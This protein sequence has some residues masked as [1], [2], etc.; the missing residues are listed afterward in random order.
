MSDLSLAAKCAF[1]SQPEAYPEG[2]VTVAVHETH[3]SYVFLT[4]QHAWK[5]KKPVRETYLDFS[6]LERRRINC[7]R[8]VHLNRRL[9]GSVYLGV[10][11]LTE[12]PSGDLRIG[13]SGRVVEWLVQ[14]RRLPELRMLDRAIANKSVT[15]EDITQVGRRLV[16]FYK[17]TVSAALPPSQY[18]QRI[19]ADVKSSACELRKFGLPRQ[20][21]DSVSERAL[22]CIDENRPL[23]EARA[24]LLLDAHGD[25]RPEHVCLEPEPV[26]I[27]CLEFSDDLRILD[28][29][30]ELSFFSIECDRLGAT[31]VGNQVL[32]V[33]QQ[34]TGDRV[35]RALLD[36]YARQH[37]L[38]RAKIA[39]WHL[40][41]TAR[42]DSTR[43]MKKAVDYLERASLLH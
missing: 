13:G 9:A 36:L 16:R 3:M 20:R 7:E 24:P 33:Y 32:E 40:K 12:E 34:E 30:S 38:T 17:T 1:L 23:V 2:T 31:W 5:L 14:M 27:D 19:Q 11:P 25:L 18:C 15:S 41:D 29:A 42:G 26:I 35:P 28:P 22:A 21:I 10:F 37:A 4:E 39:V 8:E 43:W 6:T